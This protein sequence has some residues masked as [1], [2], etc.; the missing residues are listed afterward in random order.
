MGMDEEKS[1]MVSKQLNAK[2]MSRKKKAAGGGG[3]MPLEEAKGMQS[4]DEAEAATAIFAAAN[5]GMQ[6]PKA[7]MK[8]APAKG[9]KITSAFSGAKKAK[10]KKK[11]GA[12]MDDEFVAAM[13]KKG[14]G[15][16]WGGGEEE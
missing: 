6:L 3:G 7:E 5:D 11:G 12:R 14:K 1:R 8:S 16:S 4:D 15:Y 10:G 9:K 2:V 13:G